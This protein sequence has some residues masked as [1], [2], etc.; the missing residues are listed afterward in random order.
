VGFDSGIPSTASAKYKM[1]PKLLQFVS[2]GGLSGSL[3][4]HFVPGYDQPVPPGQKTRPPCGSLDIFCDE[5]GLALVGGGGSA[6]MLPLY[7]QEWQ[8]NLSPGWPFGIR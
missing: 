1:A 7:E 8:I 5:W 2:I 4:R 3:S 6:D